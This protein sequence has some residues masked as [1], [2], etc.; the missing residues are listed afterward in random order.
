MTTDIR[1]WLNLTEGREKCC[2]ESVLLPESDILVI[3]LFIKTSFLFG[4]ACGRG[5]RD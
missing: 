4:K 1:K 3:L 5:A 2:E